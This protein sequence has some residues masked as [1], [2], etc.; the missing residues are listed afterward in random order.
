MKRLVRFI[1]LCF[2]LILN[3]QEDSNH[4]GIKWVTGLSWEQVNEKAKQE[5]KYIFIDCFTTWCSPCKK[6]DKYIYPNDTVGSYF[7]DHFV[8]IKVQIDKASN[9]NEYVKNWYEDAP[10]IAKK[11]R[12]ISYPSFIFLS[13]A[14]TIVYKETG[15]KSVK[16]LVDIA[17]IA[18]RPGMVYIDPYGEYD[19][20]VSDYERGEKKFERLP[21]LVRTAQQ[22]GE[23]T[24]AEMFIKDYEQH[25]FTLSEK[26]LYTKENIQTIVSLMKS[27]DSKFFKLF[28]PNG[29]KVNA[30]MKKK[31]YAENIVDRIILDQDVSPF[32]QVQI[33]G[34]E[35]M[36]GVPLNKPEPNWDKLYSLIKTKY[37]SFYAYRCGLDGKIAWYYRQQKYYD[38]AKN[39]ILRYD[40]YGVDR[41][42]MDHDLR[43]NW[44]CWEFFKHI[45]NKAQLQFAVTWMK[46]V[47]SRTALL[48]NPYWYSA[49]IDTYANLLYKIGRVS[50]AIK[51]EEKAFD[52]ATKSQEKEDMQNFQM[53][54]NLMKD[55]KQTWGLK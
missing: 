43:L 53:V 4:V 15:Y 19:Q 49:T 34:A 26:E 38:W 45:D 16:E 54:I 37:N 21:Y 27:T 12:I 29:D 2:P 36:G 35:V 23:T 44:V 10:I 47:V 48:N 18:T 3:A 55:G 33:G 1:F 24:R 41:P 50:E 20:L 46:S 32:L 51:W 7:N 11:Y 9:D 31:G 8:S 13:P 25:V 17:K 30:V 5:N 52:I 39:I 42:E 40:K 6:M 22:L 14:G 28:F